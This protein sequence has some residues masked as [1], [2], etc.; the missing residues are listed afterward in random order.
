MRPIRLGTWVLSCASSFFFLL[1]T[2]REINGFFPA[3]LKELKDRPEIACL[4]LEELW[5]D[6]VGDRVAKHCVPKRLS[7]SLLIVRVHDPAWQQNLLELIPLMQ[8]SI[9]RFWGCS[10]VRKIRLE[11]APGVVSS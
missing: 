7:G 2:M 10:L 6:I 3:F 11:Q 1:Q 8:K 9:N 4:F 5:S